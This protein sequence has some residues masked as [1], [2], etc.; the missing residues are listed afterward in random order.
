MTALSDTAMT[1]R[2]HPTPTD[3]E[4]AAIT[5]AVAFLQQATGAAQESGRSEPVSQWARASRLESVGLAADTR[6]SWGTHW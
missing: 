3:K 1:L 5:A 6:Q 2:V 4:L